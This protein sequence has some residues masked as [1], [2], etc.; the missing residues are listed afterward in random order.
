MSVMNGTRKKTFTT[1]A[2][3]HEPGPEF[4]LDGETF[5]CVPVAPPTVLANMLNSIQFG[6]DGE[7]QFRVSGIVSFISGVVAD[8]VWVRDDPD[9]ERETGGELGWHQEDVDDLDR[10]LVFARDRNRQVPIEVLGEVASWLAE[11]YMERPTVA[12]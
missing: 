7:T 3:S 5:R 1:P 6:G 12:P 11:S 10:W 9:P 4:T 2:V 8:K